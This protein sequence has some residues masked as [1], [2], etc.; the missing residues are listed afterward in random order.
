MTEENILSIK[1]LTYS[2]GNELKKGELVLNRLSFALKRGELLCIVGPSGCGKTTLLNLIAGFLIPVEGEI[3]SS[4]VNKKVGYIFQ[5]DALFPWRKVFGN[6]VLGLEVNGHKIYNDELKLNGVIEEYLDIFNLES[7]I[8]D[9]YP[10]QLSGGMRQR[11]SLIQS[12]MYNP[13]L[14]LLDEPFASL[15]FYTKLRLEDEFWK[16]VQKKRKSAILV[17]HD[18]DEAIAISHRILVMGN[19]PIGIIKEI[20]ID[21]DMIVRTPELVR[22]HPKFTDYFN[23]IWSELR[24]AIRND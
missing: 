21:F 14:L 23:T 11:V 13:D 10:D 20:E 6:I 9:K 4:D 3:R 22:G 16:L 18:I 17:T 5:N 12:L 2:Y 15:D 24:G 7:S 1:D 8:L 19:S